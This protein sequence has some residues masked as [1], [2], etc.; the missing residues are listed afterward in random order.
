MRAILPY[1]EPYMELSKKTT[2]LFPPDLHKRLSRLADQK[3]ISLGRLVRA[4][5]QKQYG[6]LPEGA[7]LEAVR[8]LG[9]F[10]LPI[11]GCR[12]MK[13]QSVPQPDVLLP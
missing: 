7:R 8:A 4:A 12:E 2:I 9:T 3:G 6:L 1:T 10:A 13:E 5:C 11:A